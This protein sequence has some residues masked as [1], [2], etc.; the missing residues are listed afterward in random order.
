MIKQIMI[1]IFAIVAFTAISTA[2]VT[3]EENLARTAYISVTDGEDAGP[4]YQPNHLI[5]GIKGVDGQGEWA[6]KTHIYFWGDRDYP[7]IKM[8]W[9]KVQ[10]IGKLVFYD[11]PAL[12]QHIGGGELTFSD[13]TRMNMMTGI[14]G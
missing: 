10:T 6:I 7:T 3:K 13:G 4:S 1:I 11:R 9:D 8:S 14:D 2:Q 12:N 5:D